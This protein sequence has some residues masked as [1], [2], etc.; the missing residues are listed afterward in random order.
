MEILTAILCG[1]TRFKDMLSAVKGI[2]EKVLSDRL[3]QSA[4]DKLIEEQDCYGYPPRVEY[5]LKTQRNQSD[6]LNIEGSK[7]SGAKADDRQPIWSNWQPFSVEV[8][9]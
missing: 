5:R 1:Q 3:R 4:D 7:L 2:S 6:V 8:T 9:H